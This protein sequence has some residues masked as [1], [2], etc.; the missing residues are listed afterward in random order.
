M[1]PSI[2]NMRQDAPLD[3]STSALML[4]PKSS[5]GIC[6]SMLQ[7]GP[8]RN[9]ASEH[10]SVRSLW[11]RR[12]AREA[13]KESFGAPASPPGEEIGPTK[14]ENQLRRTIASQ[15]SWR[16]VQ[17]SMLTATS[18]RGKAERMAVLTSQEEYANVSM[19]TRVTHMLPP[20]A[21]H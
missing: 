2:G 7:S 19:Q 9:T 1:E 18:L 10:A 4:H 17:I 20:S 5:L 21:P 6:L 12:R 16:S 11:V 14:Q 15:L 3:R 8:R 13:S